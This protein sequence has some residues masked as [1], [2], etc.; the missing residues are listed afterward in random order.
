MAFPPIGALR[1]SF[2]YDPATGEVTW[3]ERPAHHFN[4]PKLA[5]YINRRFAGTPALSVPCTKQGHL[6]GHLTVAGVRY[7]LL[8]H[9]VIWALVH[10]VAPRGDVDH[11]GNV[12]TDNRD[13]GL[14]LATRGQNTRNS[15]RRKPGLKGAYRM[16][17]GR[18]VSKAWQNGQVVYLGV[19][20]TAEEAHAA[21]C[22]AN[23]QIAGAFFNPGYASVFD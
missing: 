5:A 10:G 20:D 8:R 14:R 9:R 2:D 16:P 6:Q 4:S 22:A 23:A 19:F 21:W 13:S 7:R 18:Y 11:A 15:V 1:E 17:N 12:A 3:R